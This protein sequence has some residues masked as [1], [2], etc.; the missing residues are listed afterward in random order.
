M[1]IKSFNL[2]LTKRKVWALDE[3]SVQHRVGDDNKDDDDGHLLI[4]FIHLSHLIY[5]WKKFWVE[6]RGGWTAEYCISSW[7]YWFTFVE[8]TSESICAFIRW[9]GKS[10]GN[11]WSRIII[12]HSIRIPNKWNFSFDEKINEWID[13][14]QPSLINNGCVRTHT[15]NQNF[16]PLIS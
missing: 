6:L 14:F 16:Q 3:S 4:S 15:N 11:K 2:W 12:L 8:T 9:H 7:V 10:N 1:A 13:F 5:V